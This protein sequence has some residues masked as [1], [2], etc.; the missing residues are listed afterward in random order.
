MAYYP[1]MNVTDTADMFTLFRYVNYVSGGLFFPIILLVIFSITLIGSVLA[2]KPA[3]RGFTYASFVCSILSIVLALMNFLSKQYM[4]FSFFL[5]G[6][7]LIWV[8]LAEA[9]Q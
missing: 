2:G 9:P 3:Y 5:V 1:E 8:R 4:Y 7:G 6:I